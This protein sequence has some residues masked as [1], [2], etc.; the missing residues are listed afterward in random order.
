MERRAHA[1]RC[2]TLPVDLPDDMGGNQVLSNI[3]Y[4][5]YMRQT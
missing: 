2:E 4:A 3:D 5:D 1:D